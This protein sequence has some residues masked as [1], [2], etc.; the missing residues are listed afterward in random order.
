MALHS[1]VSHLK[2]LLNRI[3]QDIGKAE[4]G[5]KA[6][7]QR[8]RTMTVKMEKIAKTYRKESIANE[9]STKGHKRPAKKAAGKSKAKPA[10]KAKHPAAKHAPKSKAKAKPKA[11]SALARPRAL[12]FKRPTARLPIKR[13]GMR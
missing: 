12:A 3:S 4:G 8:V 10:A 13:A 9:K 11:K 1:T 6:A 5:N 2:D 7:S